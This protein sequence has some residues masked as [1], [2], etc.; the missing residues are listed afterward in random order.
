MNTAT[1]S[2]HY[3]EIGARVQWVSSTGMRSATF[4]TILP[5]PET[6]RTYPVDPEDF[7]CPELRWVRW[8]DDT[9]GPDLVGV[10]ELTADA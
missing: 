5:D 8:D 2:V 10:D 7:E 4:G 1:G 9:N 6:G 3:L